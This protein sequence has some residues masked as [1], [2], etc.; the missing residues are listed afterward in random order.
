MLNNQ[1]IQREISHMVCGKYIGRG[2]FREVYENKW[3]TDSVIK[4]EDGYSSFHNIMEWQIWNEVKDTHMAKWFAPCV[5]ISGNGSVLV[6][7]K[8]TPAE[9]YPN[10]IPSFFTDIKKDNWGSY[11]GNIVCHDYGY[12]DIVRNGIV[13]SMKK[14]DW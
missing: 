11:K 14:A 2:Q 4:L 9:K 10:R 7:M 12:S 5:W 1:T 13:S 3:S 6:M 8:T